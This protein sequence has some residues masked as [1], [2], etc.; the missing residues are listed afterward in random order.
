MKIC[1]IL[2]MLMTLTV[3]HVVHAC[4]TSFIIQH[5]TASD[6][7]N[8]RGQPLN[9]PAAFLQQ[10]RY[11]YHA[12]GKRDPLDGPDNIA[13]TKEARAWYG[14]AVKQYIG[15]DA[16]YAMQQGEFIAVISYDQCSVVNTSGGRDYP[17]F[18]NYVEIS[19]LEGN[20]Y[21]P[22]F[23]HVD[24]QLASEIIGLDQYQSS[25]LERAVYEAFVASQGIAVRPDDAMIT[26][27]PRVDM[28][29]LAVGACSG[30][31]CPFAISD[32]NGQALARFDAPFGFKYVEVGQSKMLSNPDGSVLVRFQ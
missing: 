11:W 2:A 23:R 9:D 16:E 27:L 7:F 21:V 17:I 22:N 4:E 5:V 8:S 6:K 20:G 12:N 24:A 10:D 14:K 26:Y 19:T 1:Q 18:I 31:L 32:R 3:G 28:F 15:P 25:D 30:A 13:T 29:L